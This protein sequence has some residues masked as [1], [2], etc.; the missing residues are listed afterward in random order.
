MYP[1]SSFTTVYYNN[2]LSVRQTFLINITKLK[3]SHV[4]V[5][6]VFIKICDKRMNNFLVLF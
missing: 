1:I 5:N 2:I 3:R 4:A 6:S